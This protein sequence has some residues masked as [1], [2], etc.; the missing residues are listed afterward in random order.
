MAIHCRHPDPAR[1]WG[2]NVGSQT[3][4]PTPCNRHQAREPAGAPLRRLAELEPHLYGKIV[5]RPGGTRSLSAAMR[6]A[7]DVAG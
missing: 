3:L 2:D 6:N 5:R 1:D 7:F 4:R